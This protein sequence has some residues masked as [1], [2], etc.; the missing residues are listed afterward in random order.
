MGTPPGGEPRPPKL[1]DQLRA[2]LRTR[3]YSIRTEE[4]YVAWAKRFILF[5]DKRHP[6]DMGASEIA[7]Y[8]NHLA[9]DRR[10]SASTQNQALS[11][12]L[13]L[14]RVVLRIDLA[15]IE[16]IARARR[17]ARLPVV[18]TRGEVRRVLDQLDGTTLIA[19]T[20]LYGSGLRLMECMRLRVR[21]VDFAR[22]LVL[23]REGKGRKD[24]PAILPRS[25]RAPLQ[26]HLKRVRATHRRDL[27][28]G[29]GRVRLPYALGRKMPS[30]ATDWSWQWVFPATRLSTDPRTGERH[31]HHLHASVLQRAVQRAGVEAGLDKRITCHVLRHSFA[32]HLLDSG[33]DIRTVQELL[34]HRS[35]QTTMIYTHVLGRGLLGVPSPA[36]RLDE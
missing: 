36:D 29:Q 30:A 6:R 2:A 22:H 5:H 25:L 8:L 14:Y 26:R 18:L 34:G 17:P 15:N 32:T 4:S 19:A 27:A 20:L 13:F 7:A 33:A 35:V 23:V 28:E 31:R 16:G 24:R 10:V 12:I 11:A 9:S 1:L 3:H 21:D